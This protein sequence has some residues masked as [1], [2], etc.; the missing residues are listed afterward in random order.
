[1]SAFPH[2]FAIQL[3][4]SGCVD[5]GMRKFEILGNPQKGF[6]KPT[7]GNPLILGNP[8]S[9]LCIRMILGGAIDL[10]FSLL[11]LESIL[12]TTWSFS[13]FS[14]SQVLCKANGTLA[15]T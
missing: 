9:S 3:S 6:A 14:R 7:L 1:M 11:P 12:H 8:F 15:G 2:R 5:T 10:G 4:G 13:A